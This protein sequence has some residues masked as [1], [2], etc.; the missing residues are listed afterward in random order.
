MN[1]NICLIGAKDTT[2]TLGEYLLKNVC[3]IDCIITIDEKTVDTSSI[4]GY[5]SISGFAA[6][7]KIALF[8]AESYA[9]DDPATIRFFR[10]NT[11]GIGICMGWQRLIPAGILQCFREGV[12]GFHGSCGY[13][14]YGRG[15]SPLNWSIINGDKRFIL[16]LFRYDEKADSPNV[17]QNRMFEISEHDTIRTLQY[18][19]LLV[20]YE[21]VKELVR[22]Y[23]NHSIRINTEYNDFDLVYKKRTPEDGRLSFTMKTRD[24]YNL[25]RGVTSPFP[26]AFCYTEGNDICVKIWDAVPFD[27]IL[28]FSGYRPG[29]VIE[30]FDG[31]PVIR[32]VDG[33]LLIRKYECEIS[34]TK[35]D[36]LL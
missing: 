11:F 7:N 28:D 29:E 15:R 21:L 3:R 36:V 5:S 18:K 17:Y 20:S 27:N 9:L 13:L 26:G 4:S 23:R 6:E 1:Y 24:L 25:I 14:P 19:N 33:S 12:F 35:G 30:V 31:M 32:T 16:N 34:L 10:E 22:D 8:E 2:I